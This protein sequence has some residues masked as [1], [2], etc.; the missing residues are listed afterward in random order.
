MG[1]VR[2]QGTLVAGEERQQ[3][4]ISAAIGGQF[5]MTNGMTVN[6]EQAT[7]LKNEDSPALEG[8]SKTNIAVNM[9]F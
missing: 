9:P 3:E 7:Q 4:A 1:A 8:E 2:Q 6:I 5:V